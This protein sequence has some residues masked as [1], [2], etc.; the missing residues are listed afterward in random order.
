MMTKQNTLVSLAAVVVLSLIILAITTYDY[1]H[2]P[3]DQH[4]QIE[5]SL[6]FVQGDDVRYCI[7]P[8]KTDSGYEVVFPSGWNL[9]NIYM[10]DSNEI[11]GIEDDNNTLTDATSLESKEQVKIKLDGST[12]LDLRSIGINQTVM[13]TFRQSTLA[14][15]ILNTESG[16]MFD[17][18]NSKD[19]SC[20]EFGYIRVA[21]SD[22]S[23][24]YD[25]VLKSIS[26]H[27]NITWTNSGI[28]K[29]YNIDLP[30]YYSILG[31]KE[32]DSFCLLA[33]NS[34]ITQMRNWI[35]YRT[36]QMLCP[37]NSVDCEYV[38]LWTNG[39]YRGLYLLVNKVNRKQ[40][41]LDKLQ[42]ETESC[43]K[44]KLKKFH[45]TTIYGQAAYPN[46]EILKGISGAN[47]PTNITGGYLFEMHPKRAG[48]IQHIY[49]NTGFR[50]KYETRYGF[51]YPKYATIEQTQ[52][53]KERYDQ[54]ADALYSATGRNSHGEHYS[55]ML[56]IESF[57]NLYLMQELFANSDCNKSVYIYKH[58]D[59]SLFRAGPLWDMDLTMGAGGRGY[60]LFNAFYVR[61]PYKLRADEDR[62]NKYAGFFPAL[63]QHEDFNT[64]VK[65]AFFANENTLL[66]FYSG[67]NC[68]VDSLAKV[69]K[70]E[71]IFDSKRNHTTLTADGWLSG[72][73]ALKQ[74]M[75]DRIAF[76]SEEW[77]EEY[78]Q[79]E[80]FVTVDINVNTIYTLI[81]IPVV[82]GEK[83]TLPDS[84]GRRILTLDGKEFN[85]SAPVENDMTLVYEKEKIKPILRIISLLRSSLAN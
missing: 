7:H 32:N 71:V 54:M 41:G 42:D 64:C 76:L 60:E 47:N 56:D 22:G 8:F 69:L 34:D 84:D 14:S 20:K 53:V 37:D 5:L 38:A 12:K 46:D 9:Y 11:D 26:G 6:A 2:Q 35:G 43:N 44:K 13:V 33:N 18:D 65:E 19:K 78:K 66:S 24:S 70:Q 77:G 79:Q 10:L 72:I 30:S 68:K 61:M 58:R 40:I 49:S 57:A 59:D 36:S 39:D 83:V 82:R 85:T 1:R 21:E 51:K 55:S 80:C 62:Q 74:F 45:I 25:G 31:F 15:V 75:T 27:G 81:C 28:K 50:S 63:C 4:D 16:S 3:K 29:P 17:I 73:S 67:Q 48:E 23:I 52:Y